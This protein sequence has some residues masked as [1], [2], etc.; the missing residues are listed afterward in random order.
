[1]YGLEMSTTH[2]KD[3]AISIAKAAGLMTVSV[4]ASSVL[5]SLLK[6]VTLGKS[7]LITALP[8]GLAAGFGSYI[9]GEAAQYYF[10]H[11]SSWGGESPK[12]VA[13]RILNRTDKQSVL[14]RLKAEIAKK[15]HINRYGA[16]PD[17][18][19]PAERR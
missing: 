14:E 19:V 10:E 3:L 13:Q 2:A 9:V 6:G 12:A 16:T 11:G 15:L 7:T 1:V 4:A 5:M 18:E 17:V 8:Q